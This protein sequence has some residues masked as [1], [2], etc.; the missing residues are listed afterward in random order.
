MDDWIVLQTLPNHPANLGFLLRGAGHPIFFGYFS[1][2]NAMGAPLLAMKVVAIGS[3]LAGGLAL[4][5]TALRLGLMTPPEA[6]ILAMAAWT[7]P[8]YE[9]WA[10]KANSVYVLSYAL[11]LVGAWLVVTF[12]GAAHRRRL[13]VRVAA[14]V[15]FLLS[16]ALNSLMALYALVLLGLFLHTYVEAASRETWLPKAVGAG[17]TTVKRFPDFLLLPVAYWGL[18]NALFPRQGIY[19]THYRMHVPGPSA[20]LSGFEA[21]ARVGYR[22]LVRKFGPE[23][24]SSIALVAILAVVIGVGLLLIDRDREGRCSRPDLLWPL[25]GALCTFVLAAL[26]YTIAQIAPQHHFYETRHLLLFGLPLGLA[27]VFMKRLL[28]RLPLRH[29]G[30]VACAIVLAVLWA[31][32][33]RDYSALQARWLKLESIMANLRDTPPIPALVFNLADGFLDYPSPHTY[34]GITEVTGALRLAWGPRP[35]VGFTR[36][37][38]RST[39]LSEIAV[40]LASEGSA[41]RD[42]NPGG[43]QATIKVEA[44]PSAAPN[45]AL[46]RR[47]YACRLGLCSTT[48]LVRSIALVRLDEGPIPGV[49]PIAPQSR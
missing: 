34:F 4:Y 36:R 6:F 24:I 44:G 38:E 25:A 42:M 17:L 35:F 13:A 19:L 48:D 30:S 27:L 29:A 8:G 15:A 31:A 16:F 33:V 45:G 9:L 39:V 3:I 22:D 47:Y 43:P 12:H 1:L 32:L 41:F 46:A 7:Y 23:A 11:F 49:D 14:L 2:A 40:L 10:G 21:F 5:A 28:D 18:L 26:P 20:M 37:G